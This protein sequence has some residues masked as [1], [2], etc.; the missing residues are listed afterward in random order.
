MQMCALS[1]K[2]NVG[3]NIR[4]MT[5]IRNTVYCLM[6][7]LALASSAAA[8]FAAETA[9]SVHGQAAEA[10]QNITDNDDALVMLEL[11][12]GEKVIVTVIKETKDELFVENPIGTMRVSMPRGK[13]ANMRK[14]TAGEMDK[15]RKLVA[16]NKPQDY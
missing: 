8:G 7:A 14:P 1:G 12:D 11:S 3:R 4:G 13:V 16:E 2:L 5:M 15:L 6:L 9:G 10:P